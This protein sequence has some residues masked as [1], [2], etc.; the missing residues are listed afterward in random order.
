MSRITLA[1]Y[2]EKIEAYGVAISALESHEPGS[3]GDHKLAY[4]LRQRLANRLNNE[5]QKWCDRTPTPEGRY[6]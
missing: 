2:T 1:Y 6:P 4:K 3:D 5:I